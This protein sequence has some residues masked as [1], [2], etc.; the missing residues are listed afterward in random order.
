MRLAV[1][2]KD[3]SRVETVASRIFL[4]KLHKLR[5]KGLVCTLRHDLKPNKQRYPGPFA[6]V[7]TVC[8]PYRSLEEIR[9]VLI[10]VDRDKVRSFAKKSEFSCFRIIHQ[11]YNNL[12]NK[13]HGSP[14]IL[15]KIEKVFIFFHLKSTAR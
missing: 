3:C 9:N 14:P 11:T 7:G 5:E 4:F 13:K 1:G 8:L 10:D 12:H 6:H 15:M 2:N